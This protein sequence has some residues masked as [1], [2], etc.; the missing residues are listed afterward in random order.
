MEGEREDEEGDRAA[1]GSSSSLSKLPGR[2]R[3]AETLFSGTLAFVAVD[4][5]CSSIFSRTANSLSGAAGG[6]DRSDKAEIPPSPPAISSADGSSAV[7]GALTPS[8]SPAVN[9]A[10]EPSLAL[11]ARLV[12]VVGM[13]EL[14]TRGVVGWGVDR[15]ARS[16]FAAASDA[17]E[18]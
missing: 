15:P 11:E 6:S 10:D 12:I 3:R 8:V 4:V 5:A 2:T 18:S 7:V 1:I 14:V 13:G 9:L 16:S 17:G